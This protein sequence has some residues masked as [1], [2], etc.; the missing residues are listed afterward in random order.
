MNEKD[1]IIIGGGPAG[2]VASIRASQLGSRVALIEENKP[3]GVCLNCGCIP[4]R[5]LLH[6]A[7]LYR[8]MKTAGQYGIDAEVRAIDL[9]KLQ[10]RKNRIIS[11]LVS[12]V[13]S[14][15][16]ANRIEV[17]DGRAKLVSSDRVEVFTGEEQTIRAGKI[18][19]ATGARTAEL[20]VPGADSPEVLD[21]RGLLELASIPG[22]AIIIGGGVIGIEMAT[23][24]NRLGCKLSIIEMMPRIVSNHDSEIVS[25][26]ESSLR[27]D[28][29]KIYCNARVEKIEDTGK[30][31]RVAFSTDG[32]T[33]TLEAEI[34]AVTTGIKPNIE[35]LGLDEC[36]IAADEDGIRVDEKMRTSVPCIYAA[37]DVAGGIMLA[38]VAFAEGRVAAENAA[39]RDS[40][41]DYR[42]IPQCSFT[43]PELAGVGLTEEE[44]AAEFHIEV[45]KFPFAASGMAAVLGKTEGFIKI[46][47]DKKSRKILGVHIAGSSASDLIA[48]A[49]LAIKQGLTPRDIVETIHAHPTLSEA[50]WE[51][52]LDVSG[53]TIHFPPRNGTES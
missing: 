32:K 47:S 6:G 13:R 38:H 29:V 21:Y 3:G 9:S 15:L 35:G 7:D 26:V 52:A 49:A 12:G 41:I 20:Q 5:F 17:I 45:G 40:K 4:T 36:G 27:K 16:S 14:L 28:G 19:L 33:E 53:E 34:V 24:L 48:E 23:F 46:I 37:G 8:S 44:A 1:I 31:K 42:A 11:G 30:N 22:S 39:G 10:A 25:V 50:F 2:Y 43:S 51:A 18:I